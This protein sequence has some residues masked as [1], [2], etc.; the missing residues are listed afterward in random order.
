MG[1]GCS[2]LCSHFEQVMKVIAVCW[3]HQWI[4]SNSLLTC[5]VFSCLL[6]GTP[7]ILW[8]TPCVLPWGTPCV[9]WEYTVCSP[10]GYTLCSLGVHRVFSPGVCCLFRCR[11][12]TVRPEL[13]ASKC[14][15]CGRVLSNDADV[16]GPKPVHSYVDTHSSA[17]P[18]PLTALP[19]AVLL[20][21]DRVL[22]WV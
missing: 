10:L 8:G 7:C 16:S 15:R 12:S 21:L 9:P 19:H 5:C 3:L 6:W 17:S 13:F 2:W 20:A 14:T 1:T 22:L 18:Y 11:P 4:S